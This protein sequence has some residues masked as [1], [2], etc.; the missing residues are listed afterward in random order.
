MATQ[1]EGMRVKWRINVDT[2]ERK[3][4]KWFEADCSSSTWRHRSVI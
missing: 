1:N 2:Y 4:L 3:Q